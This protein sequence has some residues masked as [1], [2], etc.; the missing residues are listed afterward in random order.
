MTSKKMLSIPLYGFKQALARASYSSRSFNSIVWILISSGYLTCRG[1]VG[2]SIPLY[3]FEEFKPNLD[4]DRYIVA[5][6]SIVWIPKE[7]KGESYG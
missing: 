7:A 3:G 4:I 5:F 6:N 1:G 2:L